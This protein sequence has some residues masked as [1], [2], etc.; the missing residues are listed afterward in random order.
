MYRNPTKSLPL[1]RRY[2]FVLTP[3]H[4]LFPEMPLWRQ[5]ESIGKSRWCGAF[6]QSQGL[7]AIPTMSWVLYPTFDFCFKGVESGSIVAVGM[8]GCKHSHLSFMR[9]YDAMLEQV[10]PSAIICLGDPFPD[11]RGNIIPVDY[12]GSRKT[13]R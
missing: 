5:I 10:D 8:I 1:Y 11:M 2:R 3:D 6:W 13:V 7:T 4:S 9:G 12:I